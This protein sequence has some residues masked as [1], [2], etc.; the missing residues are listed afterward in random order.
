MTCK[1]RGRNRSSRAF[2]SIDAS[3]AFLTAVFMFVVFSTVI[4]CAALSAKSQASEISSENRALR[5]SSYALEQT[6]VS[7]GSPSGGGY[8]SV[9]EIDG[10]KFVSLDLG[11]AIGA[12][13]ASFAS[14]RL[15]DSSG[16]E[17]S[18]Q[19][20]GNASPKGVY[21]VKRLAIMGGEYVGLE[22]CMS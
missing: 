7:G 10:Q 20:L 14:V 8:L 3:F 5:F 11:A 16:A 17:I 18:S 15:V 13:N 4:F 1:T 12:M 2:F 19:S 22:A 6:A 9:N 21:C